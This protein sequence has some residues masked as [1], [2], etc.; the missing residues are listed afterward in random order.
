MDEKLIQAIKKIHEPDGW[1]HFSSIGPDG[2]PHVTPLMMGIHEEGLLF[3][4][5]GK[6]KKRNLERD[7]RACVSISKPVTFG[8]VIVWGSVEIRHDEKAQ[9]MWNEM[10]RTAFGEER[11]KEIYRR[12]LSIEQTSLGILSPSHYRIYDLD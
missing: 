10:I 3:S 12:K 7:P 6:Q 4:F 2:G 5:T 1:V 9:E 11:F 8:H